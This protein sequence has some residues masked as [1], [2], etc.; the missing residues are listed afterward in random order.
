M[1]ILHL[2]NSDVI[3]SWSGLVEWSQYFACNRRVGSGRVTEID[4]WTSSTNKQGQ[5]SRTRFILR[6]S[7]LRSEVS[8]SFDEQLRQ[9][10]LESVGEVAL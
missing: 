5:V 8:L 10:D 7:D 6:G 9:G 1:L 3:I 2:K 4:R